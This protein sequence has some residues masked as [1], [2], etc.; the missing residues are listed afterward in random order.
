MRVVRAQHFREIC[1]ESFG[2]CFSGCV[3]RW[4][5][6]KDR[7]SICRMVENKPVQHVFGRGDNLKQM[8]YCG[9]GCSLK[10]E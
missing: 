1:S 9:N 7:P 4:K 3:R 6:N 5:V 10:R 2:S 8:R